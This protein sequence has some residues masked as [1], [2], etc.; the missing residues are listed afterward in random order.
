MRKGITLKGDFFEPSYLYFRTFP[1]VTP[2][3]KQRRAIE[4][5]VEKILAAKRVVGR[6]VK[7]T[8]SGRRPD[9]QPGKDTSALEKEID[10]IVYEAGVY[11]TASS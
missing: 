11:P 7:P 10:W 1:I 8:G 6:L 4:E 9:L 5:R 2:S 3:D